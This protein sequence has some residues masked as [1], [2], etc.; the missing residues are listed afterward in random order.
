[1]NIIAAPLPRPK[2]EKV[3]TCVDLFAGAGGFSL[4]AREAGFSVRLAVEH[5]R[6]ACATYRQNFCGSV[7]GSPILVEGDITELSAQKLYRSVFDKHEQCDVMLGGPPC[8][9]F[10]AHRLNNA[11]V[12]DPR[13][14][15]LAV[16]F[17]FVKA[18]SPRV[19]LMENVPGMLWPRHAEYVTSFYRNA[20][21]QGYDLFPPVVLDAR[22]YGIWQRRKRVFILGVRHDVSK[23]DF[24]W[25]PKP[26]HGDPKSASDNPNL[27]PWLACRPTFDPASHDDENDIH[28]K[29]SAELI[30]VFQQTPHNGGS[31][32]DSGRILPCHSGHDGHKDVYG[33]IDP[34]QPAP[35]MTTA[36]INPSK[37]RFVHP[38]SDH[39]I[40]VR[41][42]ARIQTFPDEFKFMGGL[43]AAGQQI[44]NAVP[45]KLAYHLLKHLKLQ[46]SGINNA[47]ANASKV[48]GW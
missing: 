27:S 19:F 9:G 8:Q 5:N 10:S 14:R 18:F 21:L 39:G 44:G 32:R 11:G 2:K 28:M 7:P 33:R 1:M 30:E 4:G 34:T 20:A 17:E 16:Y 43:M 31:R 41:Q 46:L 6:H 26:T 37:G 38:T 22:D 35:T 25:P 42:A 29:H 24:D 12:N 40:T 3:P 13:N 36:C 15:L 45:V 47:S 48:G 23:S